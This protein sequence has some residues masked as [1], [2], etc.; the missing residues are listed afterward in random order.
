MPVCYRDADLTRKSAHSGLQ[1]QTGR[2]S[3]EGAITTLGVR[4]VLLKRWTAGSQERLLCRF[5]LAAAGLSTPCFSRPKSSKFGFGETGVLSL[6]SERA[7]CAR[8][9][10]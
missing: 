3:D 7:A 9:P 8:N 4:C 10:A 2:V 5:L 1:G 6:P